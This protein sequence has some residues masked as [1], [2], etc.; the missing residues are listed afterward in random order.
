MHWLFPRQALFAMRSA[1]ISEGFTHALKCGEAHPDESC[2][3]AEE[4][5][6]DTFELIYA[7]MRVTQL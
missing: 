5:G 3:G 7:L 1:T 4:S 2:R 6:V